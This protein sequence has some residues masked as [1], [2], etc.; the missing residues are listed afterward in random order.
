[1]WNRGRIP[2]PGGLRPPAP[3]PLVR[4]RQWS[5]VRRQ[6]SWRSG[7]SSLPTPGMTYRVLSVKDGEQQVASIGETA[8]IGDGRAVGSSSLVGCRIFTRRTSNTVLTAATAKG[9][10]VLMPAGAT[11]RR[12]SG[13]PGHRQSDQSWCGN[14]A[15]DPPGPRRSPPERSPAGPARSPRPPT[16]QPGAWLPPADFPPADLPPTRGQPQTLH[17]PA[18]SRLPLLQ[19]SQ[20]R[21]HRAPLVM[22][23]TQDS[24][25]LPR[26]ERD[27]A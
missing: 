12:R 3:N 4:S 22:K 20:H 14:R 10:S 19:H 15:F 6:V 7:A 9:G 8:P 23:R 1:M 26:P 13:V 2:S 18:G 17:P 11:R 16:P 25:C 24:A 27:H 21:R 5:T